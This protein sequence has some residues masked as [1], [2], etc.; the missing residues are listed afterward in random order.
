MSLF[1]GPSIDFNLIGLLYDVTLNS[2]VPLSK[3]YGDHELHPVSSLLAEANLESNLWLITNYFG[4]ATLGL[5]N[6]N[7]IH[8][9]SQP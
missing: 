7:I 1:S 2:E 3:V 6:S 5:V 4:K 8:G 9:K